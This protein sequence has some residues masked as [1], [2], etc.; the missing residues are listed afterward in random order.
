MEP[1]SVVYEDDA[2]LAFMDLRQPAGAAPGHLLVIPKAHVA[3]LYDLEAEPAARVFQAVATVA[4]AMKRALP[5][6]EGLSIWSS[7][8]APWQEVFHLHVHLIPRR[9]GDGL[10]RV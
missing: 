6:M 1:A 7:N 4:R 2:T 9:R 8:G 5:E 10:F 3:T